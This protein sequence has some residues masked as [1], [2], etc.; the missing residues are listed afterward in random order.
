MKKKKITKKKIIII[1]IIVAIFGTIIYKK[2]KPN[3]E[4]DKKVEV[5][6]I[7][8]RSIANTISDTGVINTNTSKNFVSTLSGSK[9]KSVNVKEGDVVNV[10]D[11]IC[12]FDTEL[13]H[14]NLNTALKSASISDAQAVVGINGAARTYNDSI[15]NKS[16]QITDT[17]SDIDSAKKA[18]DE[19]TDKLNAL[20][21]AEANLDAQVNNFNATLQTVK[22]AYD[23]AKS[24]Y[25]NAKNNPATDE[26]TLTALDNKC[27]TA[28]SAYDSAQSSYDESVKALS[29]IRSQKSTMESTSSQLL[30]TYEKAVRGLNT[31]SKTADSTI[32]SSHDAL[33][34][35][36]LARQSASVNSQSQI[37]SLREQL[38]NEVLRADVSGTITKVNVK[39]G[40]IYTGTTI[41]ILDG[42]DDF[43]IESEISEYDIPDIKEGMKV[44]IKTDATR[45]EELEG[46]ITYVSPVASSMTSDQ[47]SAM[48]VSTSSN[49]TYKIKISFTHANE[50][51]RLGMNAKLS[52]ITDMKENVLAVPYECLQQREDGTYFVEIADNDDG[53][54]KHELNVQKGIE[55]TYYTEIISDEIKEGMK[56]VVPELKADNSLESLIEMMGPEAGM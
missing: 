48:N 10:G 37:D 24:E 52:I 22:A 18:F 50:R 11:V 40:D 43:V 20:R 31:A 54:E 26:A 3:N 36:E 16:I 19:S 17:Q 38:K 9:I 14:K 4:N 1:I 41:A 29:D 28:K 8:R 35:S 30:A 2:V 27:K 7:T 32:A 6:E 53:T 15:D 47:T 51:I 33:I 13:L 39:E 34:N 44:M 12:T 45:E 42:C 21:S 25:E 23:V 49:A 5:V 46:V 56:V 55:G